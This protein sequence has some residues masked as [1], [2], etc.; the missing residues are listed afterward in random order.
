MLNLPEVIMKT[1]EITQLEL[2]SNDAIK[3]WLNENKFIFKIYSIWPNDEERLCSSRLRRLLPL[4]PEKPKYVKSGKDGAEYYSVPATDNAAEIFHKAIPAGHL[5]FVDKQTEAYFQYLILRSASHGNLAIQKARFYETGELPSLPPDFI[6]HPERPLAEYQKM[7]FLSTVQ[8]PV[9]ALFMEQG[10]GK[11]PVTIARICNEARKKT[12]GMYRVLLICPRNIRNNWQ[13]EIAN[14]STIPGKVVVLRGS[15][16]RRISS[17]VEA[18]SPDESRF[19]VVI[20]SYDSVAGIWDA[21]EM[22]PW[23]LV[24]LDE[25]HFI[26]N[27]R[28]K[29]FS[30]LRDLQHLSEQRMILTGTPTGNG[31]QDLYS[32]LEFLEKGLSGFSS[33]KSFMDF[34]CCYDRSNGGN[35]RS[36]IGNL[37]EYKNL[38]FLKKRLHNIAFMI[39]KERANLQLPDKMYD[40][41]E[42]EMTV[43]QYK[44][45]QA[46]KAD[47]L[48]EA[49]GI[50]DSSDGSNERLV[51]QN[52]LTLLLKL[53][54]V[55]SGFVFLSADEELGIEREL[56]WI[57]KGL[58][59]KMKVVK[60]LVEQLSPDEK[61][62]VWTNWVPVIERLH[63]E[64]PNSVTYY[65]RMTENQKIDAETRFNG[66][67]SVKVLIGNPR[68]G[69]VGL[70]L[71]GYLR[72]EDTTNVTRVVYYSQNWSF[73][74]R[75]QSE[76]RSHRR[77]TRRPVQYTDLIVPGTIDETIYDRIQQKK[78][79]SETLQDIKEII[80]E[81]LSFEVMFE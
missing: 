45:Y 22:I 40:I 17:L 48:A 8:Q 51:I 4:F 33:Q 25:S 18:M 71:R 39:T 62:I 80:R 64:L 16:T 29:R 72:D 31:I 7:A 65:G 63:K 9:S 79:V 26:K 52:I 59:P 67:P 44:I 69:G 32:Q 50:L 53:S 34:Y 41:L 76:D 36:G 3:L 78:N 57:C 46:L 6:D 23:D 13:R 2:A 47:V 19:S 54:Q 43:E 35:G 20:C 42:S 11:T 30:T 1:D 15:D 27:T 21:V 28:T 10:T 12:D 56:R 14:F 61:M 66:D 55:T 77:G 73:L 24:V 74:D 60:E 5:F 81:L 58:P 37:I 38:P 68:S 49:E 70:N 75:A